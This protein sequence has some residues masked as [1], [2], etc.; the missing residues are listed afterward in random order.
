M[1]LKLNEDVTGVILGWLSFLDIVALEKTCRA[2]HQTRLLRNCI[3]DYIQPQNLFIKAK[4]RFGFY[5]TPCWVTS[6]CFCATIG[7]LMVWG[8]DAAET[9]KL[10]CTV[11]STRQLQQRIRRHHP[12]LPTRVDVG[13]PLC[14]RM[15]RA[16]HR[17]GR[18]PWATR[19]LVDCMD[20]DG[21]WYEATIVATNL[22][23]GEIK[24]HFTYWSSKWDTVY[25]QDSL[26]L[27]PRGT[28]CMPWRAQVQTGDLLEWYSTQVD[29]WYPVRVESLLSTGQVVLQKVHQ[30]PRGMFDVNGPQSI[31]C[32]TLSSPYLCPIGV[33][34]WPYQYR[35]RYFVTEPR[36]LRVFQQA[37]DTHAVIVTCGN[38]NNITLVSRKDGI[39]Q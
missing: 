22:T 7:K 36:C 25:P 17:R 9:D 28:I 1:L 23:R 6:W 12:H 35:K 14:I 29:R 21:V 32:E 31:V 8:D 24:V 16:P 26:C 27:L 19:D 38:D 30:S 3:H 33:H 5:W 15:G 4:I 2:L 18:G 39:G 37:D 13:L 20:S 10:L 34:A 11:Q